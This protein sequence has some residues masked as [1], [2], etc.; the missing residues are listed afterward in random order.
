MVRHI[1]VEYIYVPRVYI[2]MMLILRK[3]GCHQVE[4]TMTTGQSSVA[5]C[6]DC[7]TNSPKKAEEDIFMKSLT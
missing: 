7:T 2:S 5:V 6:G 3:T 4:I 1:F